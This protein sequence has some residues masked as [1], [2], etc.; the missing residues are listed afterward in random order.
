MWTQIKTAVLVAAFFSGAGLVYAQGYTTQDPGKIAPGYSSPQGLGPSGA[1]SVPGGTGA[2][3]ARPND[4]LSGSTPSTWGN[5]P[6]TTGY[7]NSTGG[8]HR[9]PGGATVR[10]GLVEAARSASGAESKP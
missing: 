1:S 4:N 5:P 2:L 10:A 9:T 3:G 8:Y 7:G 6:A